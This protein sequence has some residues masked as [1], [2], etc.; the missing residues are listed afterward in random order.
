LKKL[1]VVEEDMGLLWI[2]PHALM[3]RGD[4]IDWDLARDQVIAV[5]RRADAGSTSSYFGAVHIVL[6]VADPVTGGERQIRLH[7]EG[8]WTMSA[9]ACALANLG[10][11]L[12]SWKNSPAAIAPSS[13][14]T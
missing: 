7:T 6:H 2:E 3:Y 10:D 12:D 14:I 9:K 5:E 13:L 1:T 4:A 11:R 8:D